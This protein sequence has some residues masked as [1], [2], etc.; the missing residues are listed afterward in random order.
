MTYVCPI[1]AI[2][3]GSHSLIKI[4]E[5]D[6]IYYYTCPSKAKKYNDTLGIINHYEGVLGEINEPWVWVFDGEGFDFE[7]SLQIDLGI[8]LA[9]VISHHSNNL[10][11]IL[12]INA[13]SYV[14]AI[15]TVLY[16]FMNNKMKQI[17]EFTSSL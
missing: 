17:I 16:P 1:C 11:K 13:T 3:P 6:I 12:I 5:K 4:Y 9:G 7:H 14:Y 2:N 8:K 15:Y 10:E